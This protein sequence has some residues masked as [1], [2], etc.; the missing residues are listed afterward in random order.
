MKTSRIVLAATLLSICA[1]NK[2]TTS[3]H[4]GFTVVHQT[5]GPDLGY[6]KESGISILTIHGYAFKDLN[7]NGELD[8]YEDWRKSPDTRARDLAKKMSVEQIAGLMLYSDHQAVTGPVV[9]EAQK[10]FLKDDNLRAIL[11]TTVSDNETAAKWN[12]SIQGYVEGIGLG[13]PVNNSS[14]PRHQANSTMEFEAGGGGDISRWPSPLGMAATFDPELM[15]EFAHIASLEYRA[16]GIATALSPQVDVATE[17]RWW[18][19]NGTMGESAQLAADLARAYCDGFQTSPKNKSV[20]GAWGYESV[21]AMVKHWYGYGAQEGGRD[22]H[23]AH[24]EYAVYPGNQL[25][26]QKIPFTEGAFK[27]KGGTSMASAVMP[28]YSV[29]WNQAPDGSNVGGSYSDFVI[30]QE[31]REKEG[32]DGVVCTDWHITYDT[33]AL[34]N[35]G[36]GKPWG[37]EDLTIPERHYRIIKAGV[38]QFGG[39]NESGPVIDAYNMWKEEFGEESARERFEDSARRLLLN[40]FR[41]GLFENPYLDPQETVSIVGRAD[42]MEAGYNAQL[43]SVVMLKNSNVLPASRKQVY[44]PIRHN[45]PIMNVWGPPTEESWTYAIDPALVGKYFDFTDNPDEADMAIVL[46]QEPGL[47]LGYSNDDIAKGGNGYIPVSL[48]YEDYTATEAREVS[49]AGGNPLEG[50]TN[51]SYKGKT[52]KTANH[53]DMVMVQ[54]TKELMGDKPVVVIANIG[55]PVVLSE[56]EPYADAILISFG[57]QNQALLDIISGKA[58]PSGLLPMQLPANMATVEMQFEDVAFDMDCY[59]DAA[60]H[61]YNFAFGM[62]WSGVINDSRVQK[63]K[64]ICPTAE[65]TTPKGKVVEISM[66]THGSLAISYDGYSIQI[67]PVA[68]FGGKTI[69]Y[70]AFPKADAILISH[71][72]GDH[73]SKD[74]IDIL[75]KEGTVILAN[76]KSQVQL[77]DG[78]IIRNGESASLGK[79]ALQAVPAYNTTPGKE[80]L[81]PKGNGNGYILD[82]EGFKVYVSGDTEDIPELDGMKDIDVA[83]LCANSPTMSIE[84][85]ISAARR[86]SPK[87]MIPYHLSQT[88][89]AAIA[90][91]LKGTDIKV[92]LYPTL[93]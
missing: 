21:N 82:F 89:M 91:G 60:G 55:K 18:R 33:E 80:Q 73:L 12:N 27:L 75:K 32:Y 83:F 61:S 4:D 29:L 15:E 2:I 13:I 35:T 6:T 46:I 64:R 5:K 59:V 19:F 14:D 85:C 66:I 30:S 70:S 68:K 74:A 23:F 34:D 92:L 28:I 78:Q 50:F 31:L 41:V 7:K 65:F 25:A 79:I 49:I 44:M 69:E 54:K 56:I 51:R 63:Y 10:A 11:F 48:Q 17:P 24:G 40:I 52:V 71:E 16:L 8:V 43:K 42:F 39:N 72:H 76:E 90:D 62:N 86:I 77:G 9:T 58:E 1:C 84:Q 45:A 20:D 37:V 88:D 38:D 26:I 53:D 67:D 87:V 81:H 47:S 3:E 36:H 57:V 22:S 93:R